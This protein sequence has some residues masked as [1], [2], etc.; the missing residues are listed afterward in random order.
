MGCFLL[1]LFFVFRKMGCLNENFS[2]PDKVSLEIQR[3]IFMIHAE[4]CINHLRFEQKGFKI[5]NF[6]FIDNCFNNSL[7]D[8][9]SL[10][11]LYK[12]VG[13][14]RFSGV[15]NVKFSINWSVF[16]IRRRNSIYAYIQC[17]ATE[18][19]LISISELV[20]HAFDKIYR[21]MSYSLPPF[22][23][24]RISKPPKTVNI[25]NIQNMPL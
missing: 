22:T 19:S 14:Q 15:H 21:M 25:K 3:I 24:Q 6:S 7:S 11:H 17:L 8:L 18:I 2:F 20:S 13:Y 23:I 12:L 4:S 5:S 9:S 1:L 16:S 10:N